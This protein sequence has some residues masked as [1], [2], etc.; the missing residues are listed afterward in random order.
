MPFGEYDPKGC[1]NPE[2][3]RRFK[4]RTPWQRHCSVNCNNRCTYMTT[5]LP[6]RI[7]QYER[8]LAKM[9]GQPNRAS[10][11]SHLK[12]RLDGCRSKMGAFLGSSS[13]R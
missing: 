4:P 2:C 12:T 5:V 7:R 8:R 6:K 1:E 10:A 13:A 11:A 3:G 9:S